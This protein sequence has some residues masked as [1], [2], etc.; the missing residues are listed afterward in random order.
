VAGL[1]PSSAAASA[2]LRS[3]D[4]EDRGVK[5]ADC[6]ANEGFAIAYQNLGKAVW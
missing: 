4:V 3:P 6:L 2:T 1:T 5:V